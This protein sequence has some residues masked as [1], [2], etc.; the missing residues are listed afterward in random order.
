MLQLENVVLNEEGR[1]WKMKYY[2]DVYNLVLEGGHIFWT[3]R[4]A[5][6]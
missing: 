5:S 2:T 3:E 1:L 6:S 4:T